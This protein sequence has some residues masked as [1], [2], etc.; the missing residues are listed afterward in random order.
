MNPREWR[1][2]P[3]TRAHARFWGHTRYWDVRDRLAV[4]PALPGIEVVAS[5]VSERQKAY[6]FAVFAGTAHR[7]PELE[8]NDAK[9]LI[10]SLTP[11]ELQVLEALASGPPDKIIA[12][13]ISWIRNIPRWTRRPAS[14]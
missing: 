12:S 14:N 13:S 8:M 1:Q 11:R 2:G 3:M 4:I 6:A 10:G 9:R 7:D 5:Q